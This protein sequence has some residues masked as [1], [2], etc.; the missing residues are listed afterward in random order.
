MPPA[1]TAPGADRQRRKAV[2]AEVA[3][4]GARAR[5]A[6][7][8][9]RR[10]AARACAA[11]P[12]ARS[13]RATTPAP[14]S[15]G[16]TRCRHCRGR[17]SRAAPETRRRRRARSRSRSPRR[18]SMRTPSVRKRVEHAIGVVGVEQSG[19]AS[20][21]A[22]ARA[23]PAAACDW[24][25]SSSPAARRVPD[26]RA[27]GARSRKSR[28]ALIRG[29]TP[30]S[31]PSAP[32]GKRGAP[33]A[34]ARGAREQRRRAPR[35]RRRASSASM[36]VELLP[37]GGRARRAAHARWRAQMSRHISGRACRD[38][39]EIAKAAAGDARV[40]RRRPGASASS[41]TSA[42]ASRCG[43]WL[44]AAKHR[45]VPLGVEQ[46]DDRAP[47]CVQ[48]SRDARDGAGVGF[49]QRRQHDAAAAKQ[50]CAMRRRRRSARC[51]RSDVPGTK[52]GNAA[53]SAARAA[54]ITSCLVL[55]ASV[56][57]V[58]AP[59]CGAI[60]ANS[61]GICADRRGEQH[62][63]GVGELAPSRPRRAYTRD[64]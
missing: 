63:V 60:A 11:R 13:R 38:P 22:V 52:R 57:I 24:R 58:A 41:A 59:R 21:V 48:Q 17:G 5:A 53:P 45:V 23:P 50:R 42:N 49:R 15:A 30:A 56:T 35:R 10:S 19:R 9:D 36:R 3:N 16:E 1:R 7:R 20:V 2:V 28:G 62:E 39:R 18:R 43:R 46:A 12:T 55:P 34:R 40:T 25:C 8:P 51:R 44:T 14:R 6:H 33:S 4:V 61:A 27:I 31:S 26:M 64:R 47:H 32:A 54:A 37:V 29:A